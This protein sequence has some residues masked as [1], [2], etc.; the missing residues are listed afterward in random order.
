MERTC[1]NCFFSEFTR[2]NEYD[3][4]ITLPIGLCKRFPPQYTQHGPTWGDYSF[5]K[6]HS[7]DWCGEWKEKEA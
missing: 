6:V 1:N 2:K 7:G 3:E 5:P 4:I